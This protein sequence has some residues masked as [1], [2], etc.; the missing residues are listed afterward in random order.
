MVEI[1]KRYACTAAL[2]V[3]LQGEPTA[4]ASSTQTAL[5][6]EGKNQPLGA[7]A[8]NMDLSRAGFGNLQ[9]ASELP[10]QTELAQEGENQQA[11]TV[12]LTLETVPL[13]TNLDLSTANFEDP[14]VA[15]EMSNNTTFRSYALETEQLVSRIASQ[16][17]G[18]TVFDFNIG[19]RFAVANGANIVT[20]LITLDSGEGNPIYFLHDNVN[21][22]ILPVQTFGNE[23]NLYVYNDNGV[24]RVVAAIKDGDRLVMLAGLNS[25]IN[26]LA[27]L[28]VV[29]QDELRPT[30][31]FD[32]RITLS[33][34]T[35]TGSRVNLRS[36]PE[37]DILETLDPSTPLEII[38]QETKNGWYRV[39]VLVDDDNGDDDR[40]EG[41]I[42]ADLVTLL[43]NLNP[44]TQQSPDVLP[45]AIVWP[46]IHTEA[47]GGI[48]ITP[49]EIVFSDSEHPVPFGDHI[50]DPASPILR[51]LGEW[52]ESLKN[53]TAGYGWKFPD[54]YIESGI[55]M[56]PEIYQDGVGYY[57]II[58]TPERMDDGRFMVDHDSIKKVYIA[59]TGIW[60]VKVNGRFFSEEELTGAFEEW[61]QS[62]R[63]GYLQA[64]FIN[65]GPRL[66]LRDADLYWRLH[67][68]PEGSIGATGMLIGS[69]E[70]S[71]GRWMHA[72]SS[73]Y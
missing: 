10:D 65:L 57:V 6:Q 62:I 70:A 28:E 42:R 17:E 73:Y 20:K 25:Q 52:V 9:I 45:T 14:Q 66:E 35:W 49:D 37:G 71:E 41:W 72:W 53:D 60:G 26:G 23:L 54:A 67:S 40:R 64:T 48:L 39:R 58:G 33:G 50:S 27:T 44:T 43:P 21:N 31:G 12:P 46:G 1:L 7:V 38:G 61:L 2:F 24:E 63:G 16:V 30:T 34:E 29:E 18:A 19:Y 47:E 5:A 22:T 69:R 8:L 55:L 11:E 3:S 56:R 59:T 4:E 51:E 32:G 15:S 13:N 36:A 68:L